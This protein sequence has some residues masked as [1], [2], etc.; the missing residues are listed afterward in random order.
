[1][2]I[3]SEQYA[4]F[5]QHAWDD[6]R[7]RAVEHLRQ[8]MANYVVGLS[9]AE[10]RGRVDSAVRSAGKY[11]L[12]DEQDVICFL[13]AGLLLKDEEFAENP[14]YLFIHAVLQDKDLAPEER[15]EQTLT[16]AFQQVL[17][18]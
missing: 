1:M 5:E 11:D 7:R 4:I 8:D 15:A 10:L 9:D 14:K 16:L 18:G 13:D 6:F 3:R 17:I 12:A 2:L